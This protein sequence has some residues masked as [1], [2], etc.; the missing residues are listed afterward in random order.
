MVVTVR[1]YLCCNRLLMAILVGSD[2]QMSLDPGARRRRLRSVWLTLL[3]V[4]LVA[5]N[6]CA[7]EDTL[8]EG[9]T[10]DDPV[11]VR[12]ST[13]IETPTPTTTVDDL[14]TDHPIDEPSLLELDPEADPDPPARVPP[15]ESSIQAEEGLKSRFNPRQVFPWGDGF[16][17]IGYLNRSE[18][19]P[20][21]LSWIAQTSGDGLNWDESFQ[22]NLPRE[23]YGTHE[24]DIVSQVIESWPRIRSSGD[25][26]LVLSQLP[27]RHFGDLGPRAAIERKSAPA[28][29]HLEQRVFVSVTDDLEHWN[30]YEYPLPPPDRIHQ[31]LG[32][33][34]VT[35]DVVVTDE[36]WIIQVSTLTYMDI[37]LLVPDKI[38]EFAKEIRW[39]EYEHNTS[40]STSEGLLVEWIIEDTDTGIVQ[41]HREYRLWEDLG[42]SQD[43]FRDYGFVGNKP[44]H[45]SNRYSAS[46]LVAKWG[47]EPI[48]SELELTGFCCEI[49]ATDGGYLGLTDFSEPGYPPDSLWGARGALIFSSDGVT[50][51]DIEMPKDIF[52]NSER[53]AIIPPS[54][55]AVEGGVVLH[56][57]GDLFDDIS[58]GGERFILEFF[59]VGDDRGLNWEEKNISDNPCP[60][61]Y[62]IARSVGKGIL[63]DIHVPLDFSEDPET[64]GYRYDRTIVSIDGKNWFTFY[65]ETD[66]GGS[67]VAFNGNVAVRVDNAGNSYRY[68]LQ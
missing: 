59:W 9:A 31:S 43:Q 10:P 34:V 23:H 47:E 2:G 55:H 8:L 26:L 22:L 61:D 45:F 17:R 56:T 36:G 6:A 54:M 58:C 65:E 11:E 13:T 33:N 32:N 64:T 35:E 27:G 52:P 53:R 25:Y 3:F 38:R 50:W 39:I 37:G 19:D 21:A 4:G 15:D 68:E 51:Q 62:R 60:E 44:Y 57:Q 30:H 48:R 67:K 46:L 63:V 49:I 29:A 1:D 18:Q 40:I 42:I 41:P 66:P 28:S 5:S 20:T 14:S 16:L 7:R 24:T 12:N